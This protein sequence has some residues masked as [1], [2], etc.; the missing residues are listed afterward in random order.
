M[1]GARVTVVL[2]VLLFSSF[3]NAAIPAHSSSWQV[4]GP[5]GGGALFLPTISPT[6]PRRILVACDMT[7]AYISDDAGQSWRMFNLRGRVR[8]FA[9]DPNDENVIYAQSIGL[10]RSL[11]DARTWQLLYPDPKT[12]T[13]VSMANDHAGETILTSGTPSEEITA[14]AIDPATSKILYAGFR[15]GDSF[16]VQ[17]S[18]DW[19]RTWESLSTMPAAVNTLYVDRHSDDLYAI[20]EKFIQVRENHR[21]QSRALPRGIS[22]LPVI[23]ASTPRGGGLVFYAATSSALFLSEDGAKSWQRLY[24]PTAAKIRTLAASPTNPDVAY[25]S[26]SDLEGGLFSFGK[27]WFGVAHTADRGRT[28][29]LVW[30]ESGESAANLHDAWI[31]ALFGP[32][33]AGNPIALAVAPTDPNIVYSTDYGRGLH[34]VD[35]GKTWD[36]IYSTRLPD[37]SFTGR[38]LEATTSYGVHFDPFDAKR[39]FMSYTDIGLFRSEN[40]GE[41]WTSAINGVP[42]A[43]RNTTY[44]MVFDPEVRGRAWAVMSKNHDLPRPKM[45]QRRKPS[46]YEGGV[47]ISADGGK[48][49]NSSSLGLPTSAVTHILLDPASPASARVLYV[50]A[51]GR[52]VYKSS[53]G[54]QSWSLKNNGIEGSAPLAW[55]LA[56]DSAGTLYMIT[57]RRSD[58]GSIGNSGDGALYKSTDGAGHW[59]RVSLP[60]GVNGPNGLAIDPRDAQH[61]LL[62]AWGRSTPPQAQ[63]GGIYASLD[64]GETWRNVLSKDQHIYDVT[65]DPHN[66]KIMYAA[67]FESSAWRSADG[68]ATWERIPGYN[69]KWGHRVIPDPSDPGKIYITTYGGGV[70]HGPAKGD[71]TAVD[72]IATPVLAHGS[73]PKSSARRCR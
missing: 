1:N 42:A 19:G 6:D 28:W 23:S 26:Y 69:F 57:A 45:W 66:P 27:K 61:L 2:A 16:Q 22:S 7:G 25:V 73:C 29:Q 64:G 68:G 18:H 30:K 48:T 55:R 54:G 49:W 53:D 44:W 20:G 38:G 67:G 12:V 60:G 8:F 32:G 5:G 50:T 36:A 59:T 63:G 37:G 17:M 51:F 39:I 3:S 40:G 4:V 56:R 41:S 35:G 31:S 14:L 52:G 9:F 62:A 65:I 33:Y 72:E 58:D 21:W 43:W 47:C 24:L 71:L 15:R 34:S 11:D 46:D 10:W 13:G 70:W